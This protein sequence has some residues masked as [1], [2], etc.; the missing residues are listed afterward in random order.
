MLVVFAITVVTLA[1]FYAVMSELPPSATRPI[2]L[3]P[4]MHPRVV[5]EI[6]VAAVD[7]GMWLDTRRGELVEISL[8]PNSNARLGLAEAQQSE[9]TQNTT[10][11]FVEGKATFMIVGDR[12]EVVIVSAKW[13]EGRSPLHSTIT[14]R[15]IGVD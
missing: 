3:P 6:T 7:D 2:L 14:M 12:L 1:S 15:K 10:I 9:W 5:A 4:V 8:N 13:I 11:R